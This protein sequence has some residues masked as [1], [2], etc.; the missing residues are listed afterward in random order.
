LLLEVLS[1]S[2]SL[3][4]SVLWSVPI[5]WVKA[6]LFLHLLEDVMAELYKEQMALFLQLCITCVV[7]YSTRERKSEIK[8][9]REEGGRVEES[10]W[11]ARGE[12]K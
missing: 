8:W 12:R 1:D 2:I 7:L 9:G 10:N 5:W 4:Y 3:D 6:L 11:H